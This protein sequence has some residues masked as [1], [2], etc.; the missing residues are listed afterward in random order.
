MFDAKPKRYEVLDSFRGIAALMVVIYHFEVDGLISNLNIVR[1]ASFFVEFFFVLSGFVISV[2]SLNKLNNVSDVFQFMKKRL[3]RIYPL[4]VFMLIMFIPFAIVA[5]TLNIDLGNRFSISSFI[6]NIFLLQALGFNSGATWNIPSW[7]ISTE[8]YTYL[9]FALFSLFLFFKK[10]IL[11]CITIATL[12]VFV[13]YFFSSM[14]DSSF[15][16][17]FR[18]TYSFFLG[19]IAFRVHTYIKSNSL[20][21]LLIITILITVLS[22]SKINKNDMLA[23]LMPLFFFVV[24]LIFSCQSGR[25]SEFLLLPYF[26]IL[27]GL[28][29]SIYMIHGWF[30]L[31]FK[32]L[33][34]LSMR[35]GEI[36][37][38][39]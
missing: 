34:E 21:E 18:C 3:A 33:S 19:V 28:S 15:L 35:Q 6:S 36:V 9:I 30:I 16:A 13:L 5:F 32:S 29:F 14:E 17:L 38:V 7:S 24:I 12:S 4:H 27:G 39:F 31:L 25:I 22:Y 37:S 20:I 11:T 2:S 10:I 1:N 26:K 23:F 8:Y